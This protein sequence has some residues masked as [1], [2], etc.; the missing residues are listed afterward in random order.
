MTLITSKFRDVCTSGASTNGAN[1]WIKT[2]PEPGLVNPGKVTGSIEL[3]F[4]L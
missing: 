1:V 4:V 2:E 3:P